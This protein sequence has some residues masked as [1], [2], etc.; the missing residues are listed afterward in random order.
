MDTK[1]IWV[2]PR[3]SDIAFSNIDFFKS[4]TYCGSNIGNNISFSN[5]NNVRVNPNYS[6]DAY[7]SDFLI[8]QLTPMMEDAA[9]RFVF[10]NPMLCYSLKHGISGRT[11][12]INPY[13]VTS[14]SRN[15]VNMREIAVNCIPTVPFVQFEG[16]EL[17]TF[18]F[19]VGNKN[20]LIL[21]K[22]F[23]SGGYG[24]QRVSL[25]KCVQYI[26]KGNAFE[27]YILSPFLEDAVPI[28]VH[29]V[30]FDEE[31]IILPPSYQIVSNRGNYFEYIGADFH[32]SFSSNVH[33]LIISR[34]K[35]IA[36]RLR[37]MGFRGI[38]GIDYMQTK[39]EIY[40]LEIN[41]RFQ[42]SSFLVNKLLTQERKSSLHELNFLAFEG[43]QPTMDSF[44]RFEEPE[45]FFSIYSD[46]LPDWSKHLDDRLPSIVSEIFKDGFN[47]KQKLSKQAYLFRIIT[48]R[49]LCW[50]D[51]DN[52]IRLAPNIQRDSDTWRQKIN[53]LNWVCLK[54]GLLNQGIRI[55][56]EAQ[57][58][59]KHSGEV[60][61]GVFQSVDLIF[62][63]GLVINAPYKTDFSE[64]S[65]YSIGLYDNQFVLFYEGKVLSP[66]SFDCID[67]FQNKAAS[68]GTVYRHAAFWATDRLRVHHEFT[69]AFKKKEEGCGF[70][71]IRPKIGAFSIDD[72][73]E[74][75]DF[76]LENADFKHFLIGGG[77]GTECQ[78]S[79]NILK[80]AR[81][82]RSH[83]NKSIYVMCLPPTDY[84]VLL[85]YKEA[86]VDEISFN[87]EIFNRD[88]AKRIMPGKG[89]ISLEQYENAFR[90]A[91]RI[92][93]NVGAVRS[94]M[95]LGLERI[96]DFY[97]GIEWLC[98]LG[99]TP[100]VSIF[101]PMNNIT[102]SDVLPYNNEFLEDIYYNLITLVER[103]GLSLGPSCI[104]CQ[105]NTLS[106]PQ[107]VSFT[108]N[109]KG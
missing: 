33:D 96:G 39:N 106:L 16:R 48:K 92:W 97:Q 24:T 53:K 41:T 82:I 18:Q 28:N 91:V 95:I 54:I 23:S 83:S 27:R 76:Y 20:D 73:C 72:V 10:Y 52:R 56:D 51:D 85:Q 109:D 59:M 103:Y 15:K 11:I 64:I 98:N 84:H 34:S 3:E 87:I 37:Q 19:N 45:S 74:V 94:M 70:C 46:T 58:E 9:I 14:F 1:L 35:K 25:D 42:A 77:S 99:V 26:E 2:G 89:K 75:I 71:N 32:T 101:R 88:L 30:I 17:P 68:R 13:N 21:Q 62:P 60:R 47:A 40:F 104:A 100:I 31:S 6:K 65:P 36:D 55:T 107:N 49:N 7:L 44:P 66:I 50:L 78:E 38:C 81:H 12:C 69:C 105:N 79:I 90:E 5:M 57:K 29:V 63:D 61:Q 108:A 102:L 80:I 86:G 22:V 67:P 93:E 43:K 4:V 8:E